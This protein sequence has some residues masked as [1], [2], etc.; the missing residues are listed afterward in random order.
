MDNVANNFEPARMG[1]L[2]EITA[3]TEAVKAVF[4]PH[5]QEIEPIQ[6]NII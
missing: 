1:S 4:L 5:F 6:T 3:Y 2:F